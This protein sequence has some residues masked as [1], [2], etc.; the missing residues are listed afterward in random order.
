MLSLRLLY[1][2]LSRHDRCLP[3][4][5]PRR[6]RKAQATTEAVVPSAQIAQLQDNMTEVAVTQAVEDAQL[7]GEISSREE[8]LN[9]VQE[10]FPS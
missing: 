7:E 1:L 9:F 5:L 8:A 2:H 10:H 4:A 3:T 6:A